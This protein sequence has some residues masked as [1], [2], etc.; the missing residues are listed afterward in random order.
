MMNLSAMQ[1]FKDQKVS[2]QLSDDAAYE[3]VLA[4]TL[5]DV[6]EDCIT[7]KDVVVMRSTIN[8]EKMVLSGKYIVWVSSSSLT[9]QL[10]PK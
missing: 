6:S 7:L 4:G 3:N 2:I 9:P 5:I 8:T 1:I 10:N